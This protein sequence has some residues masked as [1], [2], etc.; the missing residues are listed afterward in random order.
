MLDTEKGTVLLHVAR[1]AIGRELGFDSHDYPRTAWLEELGATFVTL[2]LDNRLRG[3]I[4]SLEAHRPLMDDVRQNAIAAAFRDP[5]FMP[6]NETE[7][8]YTAVEVSVLS[9]PERISFA[10]EDDALKQ[11]NPGVDGVIFEYGSHRATFLPHA[12]ADLRH[13]K[14][15]L[16]Q[17]KSQAGLPEDFW[18]PDLKLSRFTIQKWY[19]AKQNG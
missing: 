6:L 9:R 17:L 8:A 18:S 4:G 5:R 10:S 2:M 7:F 15:L 3:C 12:W 14:D 19:E 1:S 16:A 13:A 11:L